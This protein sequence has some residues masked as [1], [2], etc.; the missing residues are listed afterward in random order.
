MVGLAYWEN[1]FRRL[2]QQQEEIALRTTS[3]AWKMRT[4]ENEVHIAAWRA[5]GTVA[6]RSPSTSCSPALQQGTAADAQEGPINLFYD[7][8]FNEVQKFIAE[9]ATSIRRGRC[10][11]S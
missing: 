9:P 5:E 6:N 4:M 8:K 1:G 2:T 7:M 3:P 10:W 11:Q